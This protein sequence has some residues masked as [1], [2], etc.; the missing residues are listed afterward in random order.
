MKIFTVD[1]TNV[2]SEMEL[3]EKYVEVT[4]PEGACYFGHNLDAFRDAVTAGGPGWPGKCEIY[5]T[6]TSRV[7]K[8]RGGDFYRSLQSIA[9]DSPF[10]RISLETPLAPKKYWWKVW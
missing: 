9:N 6:N 2:S 8:F 4:M 1:C 7:Q 10:V 5:F 3:W